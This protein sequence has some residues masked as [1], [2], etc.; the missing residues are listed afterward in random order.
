MTTQ[1]TDTNTT[2]HKELIAELLKERIYA[3]FA[4]MAVLL[5]IDATHTTP[6][7]AIVLVAGTIASLWAASIVASRMSTRMVYG[8]S[9]DHRESLR[10]TLAAHASMLYAMITPIVL[11][12]LAAAHALSLHLA[13]ILATIAAG[14]LLVIWTLRSVHTTHSGART[15]VPLLVLQVSAVIGVIALKLATSH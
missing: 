5:S 6:W 7:G 10:H 4:L 15:V 8:N 12:G 2:H 13:I 14:G 9:V 3:T 1:S 11:F